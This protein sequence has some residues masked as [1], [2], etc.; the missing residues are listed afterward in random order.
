LLLRA[1]AAGLFLLRK[2]AVGALTILDIPA[3]LLTA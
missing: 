2:R 1:S 3:S